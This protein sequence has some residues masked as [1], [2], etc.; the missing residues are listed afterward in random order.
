[1]NDQDIGH[2]KRVAY[3]DIEARKYSGFNVDVLARNWA[4]KQKYLELSHPNAILSLISRLEAIEANAAVPEGWKLVPLDPTEQMVDAS[5]RYS[6]EFM[7]EPK[8][9]RKLCR[10]AYTLMLS[11]APNPP[12][13]KP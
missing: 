6:E 2:L 9:T 7:F 11:A 1:M 8:W 10:C 13:A 5:H 12:E 3:L 4:T